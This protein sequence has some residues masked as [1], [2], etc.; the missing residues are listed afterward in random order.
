MLRGFFLFFFSGIAKFII[1]KRYRS[2]F[3]LGMRLLISG[4]NG[5]IKID[6]IKFYINDKLG[7][8][9]QY[10]EIFYREYY[11]FES[12][13][14]KQKIIVD[15][16]ANIGLSAHWF[17][18]EY[19]DAKVYCFEPDPLVFAKLSNNLRTHSSNR[20]QLLNKAVFT[21]EAMLS[22]QPDGKDGGMLTDEVNGNNIQVKAIDFNSFLSTFEKVDMLKI[23]IEGAEKELIPHISSQL[24]K[25]ENLFIEY[26]QREN[27][28]AFL[29]SILNVLEQANFVYRLESVV[30]LQNPI[31]SKKMINGYYLQANIFATKK[32]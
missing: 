23:D 13:S 10:Y 16:G 19:S 11:R 28:E 31:S 29:S 2:L 8:F 9:W 20:V 30:K 18:R 22:F 27:E 21:K 3:F 26:H 14:D 7:L 1:Q 15:C 6:G 17:L 4:N 32:R 12:S 25:V 5:R 24:Y